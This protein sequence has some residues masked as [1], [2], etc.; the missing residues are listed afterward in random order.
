MPSIPMLKA[1]V[2]NDFKG[3]TTL[4]VWGDGEGMGALFAGLSDLRDGKKNELAI[5][6]HDGGL[7]VCLAADN[8]EASRLGM[9]GKRLHWACSPE[10]VE[11]AAD[12]VEPLL[13]G[14]GHQFLD[15]SGLAEQVIIARDEYPANLR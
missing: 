2:F 3:A 1:A 11:L 7:A 9:E 5:D 15:V 4:L 6:G 8:A 14:A 13:K 12:L 10:T